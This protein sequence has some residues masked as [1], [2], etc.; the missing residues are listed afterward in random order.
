MAEVA[1][2]RATCDRKHVGAV[3]V[4]A[5]SVVSTGY[6]G[7]P[8]GLPH[9][10]DAGHELV[11][12]GGRMSCVR[13]AHA[14]TNAIAQAARRGVSVEGGT[15]YTTASCCYDCAKLVINAGIA[16]V[17]ALES[18]PGRYGKSGTVDELF[19]SAG[20]ISVLLLRAP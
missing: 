16:R 17:V 11:E 19:R 15:L 6:N 14:E 3:I 12:M 8:R 7:A 18:Y 2:Q 5:G 10:D 13:T 9:C 4:V 20:V 1:A